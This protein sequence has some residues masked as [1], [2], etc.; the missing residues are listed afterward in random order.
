HVFVDNP[1]AML[2]GREVFGFPK[3]LIDYDVEHGERGLR[4][5]D[6][7]ALSIDRFR[8]DARAAHLPLLS[9]E[10]VGDDSRIDLAA[11]LTRRL[12]S[13]GVPGALTRFFPGGERGAP[14]IDGHTLVFLK[15]FRDAT[16]QD[17]ACYQAI[18]EA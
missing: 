6:V 3:S 8:D 10:R 13:L 18:V 1:A 2:A 9:L 17:Q 15:Q 14:P 5:L 11:S 7:R 16:H 12:T 4:R